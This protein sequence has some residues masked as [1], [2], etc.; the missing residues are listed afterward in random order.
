[1]GI[2]DFPKKHENGRKKT[3]QLVNN[4]YTAIKR[5]VWL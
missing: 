5:A 2:I 1:M 3:M 4:I